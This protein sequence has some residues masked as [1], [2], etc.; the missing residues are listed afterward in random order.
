MKKKIR[1]KEKSLEA[2]QQDAQKYLMGAHQNGVDAGMAKEGQRAKIVDRKHAVYTDYCL[3]RGSLILGHAN[4]NVVLGIKKVAEKGIAFDTIT[5]EEIHLA[6]LVAQ[7]IPAIEKVCFFASRTQALKAAIETAR[8]TTQKKKAATFDLCQYAQDKDVA[9]LVAPFND[10]QALENL[11]Q[12]HKKTLACIVVEA[13]TAQAGV[14]SAETAFLETLTHLAQKHNFLIILDEQTTGL[15]GSIEGAQK[16]FALVPDLICLSGIIG[17]GFPLALIGASA[18]VK[19]A[20]SDNTD[21][22]C[23][24]RFLSPVMLRA[25]TATLKLLTEDFYQSLNRK[26]EDFSARINAYLKENAMEAR[27]AS[28]RSMMSV[29]FSKEPVT[30]KEMSSKALCPEKYARLRAHLL[31]D[32]IFFPY[33]QTDP[34]F[35]SLMHSH[36]ELQELLTSLKNFFRVNQ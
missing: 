18:R 11:V 19:N 22:G 35:F 17:G 1:Y 5:S 31:S 7:N 32:G 16:D 27:V 14:I 6:K 3:A 20:F 21:G 9:A 10:A 33:E 29:F 28:Y 26:A 4:R 34:F 36:K 23:T 15:R 30:N 13:V 12:E 8:M 2:Y 24:H 25:G